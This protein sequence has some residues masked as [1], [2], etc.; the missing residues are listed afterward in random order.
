MQFIFCVLYEGR[1]EHPQTKFNSFRYRAE[2]LKIWDTFF[3]I[4]SKNKMTLD[5][6]LY[7]SLIKLN[8]LFWRF[9]AASYGTT[10]NKYVVINRNR[11]AK[12][13]AECFNN[14]MHSYNK[15]IRTHCQSFM[16]TANRSYNY[17]RWNLKTR[18]LMP[19]KIKWQH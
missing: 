11:F 2:Q 12:M 15:F 3:Y 14:W 6:F 9:G 19:E 13:Y 16:P 1:V 7:T 10:E 17:L 5:Y 8:I 18:W 4:R